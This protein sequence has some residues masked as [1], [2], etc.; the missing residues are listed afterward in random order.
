MEIRKRF[1]VKT[2]DNQRLILK[3]ILDDMIILRCFL[4]VL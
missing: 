4:F 3:L 2:I 1:R